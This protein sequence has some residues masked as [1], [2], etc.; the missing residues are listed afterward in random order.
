MTESF[1]IVNRAFSKQSLHYDVDDFSNVI[2]KAWREQVYNHTN[3]FLNRTD[4]ILELNAGTGIDA[5]HFSQQGHSVLATDLSNGMIQQIQTKI[6]LHNLQQHLSCL[7]L[8]YDQLD[9]L[10]GQKFDYVFSNF[11]GLNCIDDLSKVTR[12]LPTILNHNAHV[13]WVIMPKVS[14]WESLGI[15][16]GHGPKSFRRLKKGGTIAHLEGEYFPTYYHSLSDIKKAFGKSFRLIKAEGLGVFSPPP[17]SNIA[18]KNPALYSFLKKAD[19]VVR[20]NFPFNRWADH[21]IVTFEFT[22]L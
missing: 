12:H 1:D 17:H 22:P 2:L 3:Q 18:V 5:L 4:R 9:K 6:G 19:G 21:I 13:T 20:N 14:L 8:S 7:Q 10:V 11:G 16:K 15:L